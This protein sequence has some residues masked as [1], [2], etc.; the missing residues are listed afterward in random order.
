MGISGLRGDCG[1]AYLCDLE[2][3]MKAIGGGRPE[4]QQVE[5]VRRYVAGRVSENVVRIRSWVSG[6]DGNAHAVEQ[7]R[8]ETGEQLVADIVE[9]VMLHLG[10][11]ADLTRMQD[12]KGG[13]ASQS[14]KAAR[15]SV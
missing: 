12:G 5:L 1:G 6:M 3:F 2:A 9:T 11:S 14:R 15:G 4:L 8:G 10:H 13:R 7:L